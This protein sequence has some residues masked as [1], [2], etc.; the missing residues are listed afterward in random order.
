LFAMASEKKASSKE[1]KNKVDIDE[2]YGKKYGR[3]RSEQQRR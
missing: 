1:D 3:F 2:L